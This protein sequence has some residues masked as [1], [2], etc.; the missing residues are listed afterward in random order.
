LVI[1]ERDLLSR[2]D[3]FL[4]AVRASDI[5]ALVCSEIATFVDAAQRLIA[6][7]MRIP[8]DL[9]V[10]SLTDGEADLPADLRPTM[11]CLNRHLIGETAVRVL[12]ER[13]RDSTATQHIRFP[14]QLVIGNT[15]R[16]RRAS[17]T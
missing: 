5:T 1:W 2:P 3:A 11:V 7:G 16:A 15:T 13:M 12:V 10:V 17:A 8:E 14:C 6:A 4:Q 9:S